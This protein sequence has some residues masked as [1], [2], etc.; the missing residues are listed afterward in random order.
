MTDRTS[1]END[2]EN[3]IT[4]SNKGQENRGEFLSPTS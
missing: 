2:T 1:M 3:N 4:K